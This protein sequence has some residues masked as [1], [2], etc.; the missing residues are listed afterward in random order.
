MTVLYTFYTGT[1]KGTLAE[2]DFNHLSVKASVYLN[3]VTFNRLSSIT[4]AAVLNS[5]SLAFCAVVDAMKQNEEG[6]IK[7]ESNDGVSVTYVENSGSAK[8]DGRRLREA[9]DLF[10]GGTDLLYRGID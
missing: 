1:Y 6:G 8:T 3:R 5:A 2:A 9:V 10:L 4:D 7:S